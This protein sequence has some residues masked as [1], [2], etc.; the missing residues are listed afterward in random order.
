MNLHIYHEDRPWEMTAC[1][2]MVV[3]MPDGSRKVAKP[4]TFEFVD[5]PSYSSPSEPTMK[6]N[7]KMAGEFFP[8]LNEAMIRSGYLKPKKDE[9]IES[10]K[11]HLEDMRKL[12]FEK[13]T[14]I[15]EI[16]EQRRPG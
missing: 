6:F 14:I 4:V 1:F 3:E 7:G 11:Y 16:A 10:I 8:A 15:D 5:H 12:V 9:S 13:E 2:W